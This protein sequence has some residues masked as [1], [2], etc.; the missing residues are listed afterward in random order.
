MIAANLASDR[1]ASS[2]PSREPA[3]AATS[4]SGQRYML[5][6]ASFREAGDAQQLR[7]PAA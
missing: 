5:Q 3:A 2:E 1:Q 7:E 6:A 4:A